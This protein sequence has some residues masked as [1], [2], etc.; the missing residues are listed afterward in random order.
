MQRRC[1][2]ETKKN[3]KKPTENNKDSKDRR[4]TKQKLASKKFIQLPQQSV[5]SNSCFQK[6]QLVQSTIMKHTSTHRLR[7]KNIVYCTFFFTA[8]LMYVLT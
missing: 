2:E 3:L 5:G 6:T 8:V 4:T 7:V 1:T